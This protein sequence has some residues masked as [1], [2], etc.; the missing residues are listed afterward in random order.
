MM[1]DY[2]FA[3][4]RTPERKVFSLY[5]H[6]NSKCSK[7]TAYLLNTF[8]LIPE[9]AVYSLHTLSESGVFSELYTNKIDGMW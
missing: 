1:W 6:E 7:L 5:F 8:L 2:I 4:L 9:T 3:K